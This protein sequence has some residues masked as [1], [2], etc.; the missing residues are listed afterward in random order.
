MSIEE[1]SNGA[2]GIIGRKFWNV[3]ILKYFL[4]LKK[5]LLMSDKELYKHQSIRLKKL[6][7][8]AYDTVPFYRKIFRENNLHPEDIQNLKDL[9]KIPIISRKDL[10]KL[11]FKEKVSRMWDKPDLIEFRT[12]GTTG[13]PLYVYV[14]KKG[15]KRR[16]AEG[17]RIFALNNYSI[18]D[19]TAILQKYPNR[20]ELINYLGLLRKKDVPYNIPLSEQAV[21]L[22]KFAPQIIEGYPS[23]ISL[24]AHYFYDNNIKIGKPKAIFTNSETLA[25]Q[26]RNFIENVFSTK[27]TDVYDSW[28]FGRIAW[29]CKAHDGLHISSDS[30]ILEIIKDNKPIK[31]GQIGNVVITDLNNYAMPFI[32]YDMGD[33][34]VKVSR[35][36]RCGVNFPLLSKIVGRKDDYLV[37]PNK[38]LVPSVAM[39]GE[40]VYHKGII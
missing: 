9:H 27:V 22:K 32:R 23:R 30:F 39:W 31:N 8:H 35:K 16:I 5:N 28:E 38:E 40:I 17:Y 10:Q 29:E 33:L 21:V 7:R 24:L 25:P 14:S 26:A 2:V 19:K 6:V 20:K 3:E 37:L 13:M 12:G 15:C 1:L 11:S 4:D 18:F 36:C 34:A